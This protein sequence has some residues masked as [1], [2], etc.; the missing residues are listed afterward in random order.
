M[1]KKINNNGVIV[2]KFHTC[3][4][5]EGKNESFSTNYDPEMQGVCYYSKY[6]NE[7]YYYKS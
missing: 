5:Y 4:I 7:R 3:L 2:I 6:L 1:E